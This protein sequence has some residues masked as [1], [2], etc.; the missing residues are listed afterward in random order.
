MLSTENQIS[1]FKM[2][3]LLP[4]GLCCLGQLQHLPHP[5]YAPHHIAW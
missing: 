1:T 2:F 5:R 3:I 4:L